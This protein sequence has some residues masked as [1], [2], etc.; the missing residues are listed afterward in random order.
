MV[1]SA[2]VGKFSKVEKQ[3][4]ADFQFSVLHNR[5]AKHDLPIYRVH[6]IGLGKD[7]PLGDNNREARAK[8]RSVELNVFSAD[9]ITASI[10]GGTE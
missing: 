8:K 3:R 6:M 4:I 10:S 7:R 1:A 9:Q 2:S 5:A